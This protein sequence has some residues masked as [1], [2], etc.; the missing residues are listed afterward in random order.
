MKSARFRK[1]KVMCFHSYVEDRSNT[2]I[3][4]IIY[5]YKY[6]QNMFPILG[7]LEE[8]MGERMIESK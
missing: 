8:T 7:L 1:T 6:I 3:S 2:N 5:T 4:I